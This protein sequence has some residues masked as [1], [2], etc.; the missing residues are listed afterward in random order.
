MKALV[1]KIAALDTDQRGD[2]FWMA[3][4]AELSSTRQSVERGPRR[5]SM[6]DTV[7]PSAECQVELQAGR[8]INQ[9]A[10]WLIRRAYISNKLRERKEQFARSKPMN[11][12]CGTFNV[13][14]KKE[15]GADIGQWL[16]WKR[17][18]GGSDPDIYA[19]GFQEIVDLNAVNVAVT[20][21][22]S[23]QRSLLW[24]AAIQQYLDTLESK[25]YLVEHLP[26][27]GVML[28]VF[29]K[30]EYRSRL[31]NIEAS[32]MGNKGGVAIRFMLYD[33]TLCFV[34]AHLAAH[35][36]NV[37]G[38]NADFNSI[39]TKVA[40]RAPPDVE[41][42]FR[43][44]E[45]T[46]YGRPNMEQKGGGGVQEMPTFGIEDHDVVFWLG[47]LN[48]RII[49]K[50]AT[51]EVLK[52]VRS[53]AGL[54]YLRACDQLNLERK[55]GAAFA[56]FE[57]G[58]LTFQPTYK[59]E[60][61]TNHYDER[62]DKKLRAPAWC[63]RVLW[64]IQDPAS[65]LVQLLSYDRAELTLS[66]HKPVA[67][68]LEAQIRCIHQEAHM[69]A[70]NAV[71]ADLAPYDDR[72]ANLQPEISLSTQWVELGV[73]RYLQTTT[74]RV[75]ITNV[76]QSLAYVRFVPKLEESSPAPSWLMVEPSF[77][78]LKPGDAVDVAFTARVD[79]SMARAL[80]TGCAVLEEVAVLRLEQGPD[81]YLQVYG[82]YAQSAF[83]TPLSELVRR[84]AG[85]AEMPIGVP[86]EVWRLL[87]GVVDRGG[88][89]G[90]QV[91]EE[92][93]ASPGDP[94]DVATASACLDSGDE[95]PARCSAQ[96]LL[97]VLQDLLQALP[98][99]V[100]PADSIKIVERAGP[101]ALATWPGEFLNSL[102]P[103]HH[104][105]FIYL[106]AF[107]R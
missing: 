103:P 51:S 64:R 99:P 49:E 53:P 84:R 54:E 28:C 7:Q 79:S 75:R 35:R 8:S 4:T 11:I 82:S 63:D 104:D 34:C 41:W 29:A 5:R 98:E 68:V 81:Y 44:L 25:Y 72:G 91:A 78:L 96:S 46:P 69:A 24:R 83:G 13:N 39:L 62:P 18:A 101:N 90:P 76:G 6:T 97:Q 56:D 80:A 93:F 47:D 10:I 32:K 27:V 71:N 36:G 77:A 67:A 60:V 86:L 1:T 85:T 100:V 17:K 19:I 87:D 37:L 15:A 107:F 30:E 106:M 26:L 22:N 102:P 20:N 88:L 57:E 31:R 52:R 95:F 61:G 2:E 58:V 45:R 38:R 50:V 55:K 59:Y 43:G 16:R 89:S 21:T 12:F 94:D 42:E 40:F 74:A 23:Q 14:G 9:A 33:S 65:D 66:D 70:Y 3:E 73:V 48:Y 105:L 92:L